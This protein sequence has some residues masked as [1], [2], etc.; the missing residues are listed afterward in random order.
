MGQIFARHRL[1]RA[2]VLLYTK[3]ENRLQ[4]QK[5]VAIGASAGGVEALMQLVRQ[6]PAHLSAPVLVVLHIPADSPS[7]LHDILSRQG[8][9]PAKQAEDG[10]RLHN[11]VIY[12]APP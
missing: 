9:L 1:H 4:S 6:L 11:G 2:A 5:I 3:K 7:L 8:T 10:E 12:V